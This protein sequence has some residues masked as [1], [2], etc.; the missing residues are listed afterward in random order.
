MRVPAAIFGT[1]VALAT[2]TTAFAQDR[3]VGAFVAPQISTLG[4]GA[5]AGYRINDYVGVRGGGNVF[6]L[7][8]SIDVDGIDY[9]GKATLKSFGATADVFPFGGGFHVSGGLRLNYNEIDLRATPGSAITIGGTTY[10][11]AQAGT[12]DG[13]VDFRRVSP[14]LGIGW[15]G[16]LF[17]PNLH[18][19][20][21]LGVMFQGSPRV[22]LR[23]NSPF[24]SQANLERE[25]ADIV[26]EL[27]P[28][29]FY[30]V[31]SVSVGYRF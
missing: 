27:K 21:D 4:L 3:Q 18:F 23:S 6:R 13:K 30:P 8:R 7:N 25:R 17:S 5:E 29:R 12:L 19:G 16:S 2:T 10:T 9:H 15:M 26:D 20:A 24:V 11:P 14:Y 22:S 28:Y 1:V 31:V